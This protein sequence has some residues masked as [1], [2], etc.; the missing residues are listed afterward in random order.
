M[1]VRKQRP[2]TLKWV[3]I[4]ERLRAESFGVW[5]VQTCARDMQMPVRCVNFV[6]MQTGTATSG[7]TAIS[8]QEQRMSERFTKVRHCVPV[9]FCCCEYSVIG[10]RGIACHSI[11]L[12][13]ARFPITSAYFFS[14]TPRKEA[15][16]YCRKTTSETC[17]TLRPVHVFNPH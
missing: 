3:A 11:D 14:A 16:E 17:G 10:F 8:Q 1:S 13:N 5:H 6:G 15:H 9:H 4:T 7:P 2:R 12:R